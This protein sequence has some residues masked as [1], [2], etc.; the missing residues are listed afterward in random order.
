MGTSLTPLPY[1]G[2]SGEV[3]SA[4]VPR[5]GGS[6]HSSPPPRGT[7]PA[8]TGAAEQRSGA[9]GE[10]TCPRPCLQALALL[11]GL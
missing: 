2:G 3:G 7:S 4:G 5:P 8:G 11:P 6:P 9:P 10:G 1:P